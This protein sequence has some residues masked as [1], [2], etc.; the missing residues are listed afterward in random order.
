MQ[1][2]KKRNQKSVKVLGNTDNMG[3]NEKGKGSRLTGGAFTSR[4]YSCFILLKVNS[5]AFVFGSTFI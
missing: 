1:K 5:A 4:I 2:R 3:F